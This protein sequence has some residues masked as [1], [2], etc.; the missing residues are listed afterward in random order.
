M[1]GYRLP[2]GYFSVDFDTRGTVTDWYYSAQNWKFAG[3]RS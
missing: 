1:D 3:S 2:S